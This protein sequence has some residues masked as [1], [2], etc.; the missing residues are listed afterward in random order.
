M[1][2]HNLTVADD[3]S[4][5][6]A[7]RVTPLDVRQSS[8]PKAIRG[9]APAAV[10]AFLLDTSESFEQALRDNERLRQEI[11]RLEGAV[12]QHKEVEGTLQQTLLHAQKVSDDMRAGAQQEADR[13]VR[14]AKGRAELVMAAAQNRLE[15]AQREID[16]LKLRRR[17]AECTIESIISSLQGTLEFIREQQREPKVVAHRLREIAS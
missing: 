7:R 6:S 15:D 4:G 11:S 12:R 1:T 2:D 17:E 10:H 14:E 3:I 16:G 8:F 9:Y 13:I 5:A